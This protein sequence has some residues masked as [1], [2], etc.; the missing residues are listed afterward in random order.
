MIG[1]A[2]APRRSQEYVWLITGPL[3]AFAFIC[4]VGFWAADPDWYHAWLGG[5]A[6]LAGVAVAGVAVLNVLI[7]RQSATVV[8]TE[9]PL[10]LAIYFLPPVMVILAVTGG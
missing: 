4:V 1:G 2:P 8:I 7:R 10:V 5:L 9:V 6:A 3:A